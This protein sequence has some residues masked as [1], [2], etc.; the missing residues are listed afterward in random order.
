MPV[1]KNISKLIERGVLIFN[2]ED[3]NN[4]YP[5]EGSGDILQVYGCN[6]CEVIIEPTTEKVAEISVRAKKFNGVIC[7]ECSE[8]VQEKLTEKYGTAAGVKVLACYSLYKIE[9]SD[10]K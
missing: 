7:T 9:N 8:G 3:S 4:N 2:Y 1:F 6:I 5:S 10:K